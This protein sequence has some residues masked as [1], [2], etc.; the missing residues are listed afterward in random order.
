MITLGVSGRLALLVCLLVG[1]TAIWAPEAPTAAAEPKRSEVGS[2]F[3][4]DGFSDLA[5]G[6]KDES[7]NFVAAVVVLY[8]SPNGLRSSGRQRLAGRW[9]STVLATGNFNGDGYADLA[10]GDPAGDVG[11]RSR[12]GTVRIFYGTARGLDLRRAQVWH[13]NRR[14]VPGKAE[15]D[16]KFGSSLTTGDFGRGRQDDLA[17]G[18]PGESGYVREAGSVTVLYGSPEGLTSTGSRAWTSSTWGVPGVGEMYEE[19]GAEVAAGQFSASGYDDLAIGVPDQ[20]ENGADAAGAVVVLR[21]SA[22]GL[23]TL[24]SRR[25]TQRSPGV[26]GRA[27]SF[28]R[29]GSTLVAGRF[30]R[31]GHED[32]AIAGNERVAG[33]EGAG[34]VNMLYGS[35]AG[36]TTAGNEM[37]TQRSRGIAG[38]P[39]FDE[40]FGGTLAAGNV[41]GGYRDELIVGVSQESFRD[42]AFTGQVHVVR[43]GA[44]GV[45]STGH[46]ILTTASAGLRPREDDAF[47][48]QI[49]TGRFGG[50]G[51]D[52]TDLAVTLGS[53]G[54]SARPEGSLFVFRGLAR[55]VQTRSAQIWTVAK[56]DPPS[57]DGLFDELAA[58]QPER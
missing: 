44:N 27:E 57:P 25:W 2:D 28:D 26:V 10:I 35:S 12:A 33:W 21:G 34:A 3:N 13:Q 24:G 45:A 17:I 15:S 29:F 56:V 4:G 41:L 5:I 31:D 32:L 40:F 14:G 52:Y 18:S 38:V 19:F 55:G 53:Q 47:G 39:E 9:E 43:F 22:T 8:G 54:G 50:P 42:T 51:R 16:D 1:S 46:Q 7:D 20:R 30:G 58:A 23:S 6:V 48:A 37:L 11:R 36:L 49:A